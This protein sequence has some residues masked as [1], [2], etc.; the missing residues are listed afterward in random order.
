MVGV[1]RLALLLVSLCVALDVAQG[2]APANSVVFHGGLR[3]HHVRRGA[4]RS[5]SM[6]AK[7]PV[8]RRRAFK[9]AA[10]VLFAG[11]PLAASA[12]PSS[13]SAMQAPLQD[14]LS[15]GHWFGQLLGVNSH[16]ETWRFE[17]SSKEEVAEALVE[18]FGELSEKQKARLLIP[19]FEITEQTPDH[20]H[21]LTWTKIEW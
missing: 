19:N 13:I 5:L 3:P 15:P 4:V 6:R 16:Q 12:A 10:A 17:E 14:R 20:V 1:N 11:F 21:V 18:V 9:Q 7:D 2:F 8:S